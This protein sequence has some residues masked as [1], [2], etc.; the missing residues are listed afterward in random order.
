MCFTA[1]D[2]LLAFFIG[3]WIMYGAMLIGE[4]LVKRI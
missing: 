1:G 3:A 2:A 4:E